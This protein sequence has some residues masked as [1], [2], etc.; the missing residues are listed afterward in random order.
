MPWGVAI[1]PGFFRLAVDEVPLAPEKSFIGVVDFQSA[2]EGEVLFIIPETAGSMV[3][4]V[5][6]VG[7]TETTKIPIDLKATRG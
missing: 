2:K 3:L 4:Q 5:G 6:D 7:G 1:G